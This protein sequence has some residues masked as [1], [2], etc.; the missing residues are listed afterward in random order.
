[1]SIKSIS[2]A[3]IF[4][5]VTLSFPIFELSGYGKPVTPDYETPKLER[6]KAYEKAKKSN[7][8]NRTFLGF[9]K[10]SKSSHSSGNFQTSSCARVSLKSKRK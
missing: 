3:I 5:L 6:N 2:L 9:F 10:K 1:M 4:I 7:L 8:R